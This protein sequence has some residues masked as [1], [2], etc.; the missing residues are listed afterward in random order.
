MKKDKTEKIE[1]LLKSDLSTAE[2]SRRSGV[3]ES[4]VSRLRS[5]QCTLENTRMKVFFKL[6]TLAEH[7]E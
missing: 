3:A 7:F 6:E 5:G 2:I 4:T 1:R